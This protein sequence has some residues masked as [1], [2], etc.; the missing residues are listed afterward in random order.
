MCMYKSASTLIVLAGLTSVLLIPHA[1]VMAG[2]L[3]E[4]AVSY[5]A[6][7]YEL[8]QKGDEAGALSFYQKAS[9]L[10]PIYPTPYND[11][12]ILLEEQGRLE[13]A[14]HAYLHALTLDPNYLQAY[15][16]LAMLYERMGKKEKA[17]V[18]WLKRYQLGD[19]DDPG[20]SRAGERLVAS[21][22]LNRD[23][24]KAA[25]YTRRHTIERELG[26]HANSLKEFQAVT[27]KHSDW[28]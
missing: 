10:D 11:T 23:G 6:Q 18:H 27:A 9:N 28:P 1:T 4:E 19:W 17:I 2:M 26:D 21:G 5:R 14:E 16:N 22:I 20:T 7:G 3:R 15:A 25:P 13:E 8:Q 24:L 12:G